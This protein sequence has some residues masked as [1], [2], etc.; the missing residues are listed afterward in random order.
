MKGLWGNVDGTDKPDEADV[1]NPKQWNLDNA[2]I[3]FGI[4][5]SA[6]WIPIRGFRQLGNGDVLEKLYYNQG[7]KSIMSY[8]CQVGII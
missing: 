2:K 1:K 6:D 5:G 7:E 8:L 4:L 3:I